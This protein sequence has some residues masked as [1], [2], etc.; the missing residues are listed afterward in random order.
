MV[1]IFQSRCIP[2]LYD[3]HGRYDLHDLYDLHNLHDMYDMYDLYDLYD[4]YGLR[5]VLTW[6]GPVICSINF[7]AHLILGW[8]ISMQILHRIS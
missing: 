5:L 4:L 1:Q 7:L 3:L 6:G 8:I 2:H